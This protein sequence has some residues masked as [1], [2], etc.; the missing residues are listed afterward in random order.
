MSFGVR[1]ATYGGE[2]R[3][4]ATKTNTPPLG[5]LCEHRKMMRASADYLDK[6]K[7]GAD[8]IPILSDGAI[9]HRSP[10]IV[11]RHERPFQLTLLFEQNLII[12]KGTETAEAKVAPKP[13]EP[14]VSVDTID[15]RIFYLSVPVLSESNA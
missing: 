2:W 11:K 9:R 7:N 14:S 5:P 4:T 15:D 6:L 8:V 1:R 13:G 10:S 3:Y 12:E